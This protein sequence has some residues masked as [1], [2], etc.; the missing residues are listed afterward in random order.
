M[1][2][3]II[4]LFLYILSSIAIGYWSLNRGNSFIIGLLVSL[5]FTPLIGLIVVGII[6]KKEKVMA[7]QPTEAVNKSN[8]NITSKIVIGVGNIIAGLIIYL[9]ASSHSPHMDPA[10]MLMNYDSYVLKEPIYSIIIIFAAILG[11]GGI[12]FLVRDLLAYN[13]NK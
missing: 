8:K 7:E 6:K 4:Y 9:W 5:L 10:E 11:I 1:N 3:T 12:A 13:K 2:P